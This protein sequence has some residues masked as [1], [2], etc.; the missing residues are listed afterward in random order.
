MTANVL[1]IAEGGVKTH[2][3]FGKCTKFCKTHKDCFM[4]V[5]PAFGNTLLGD[6][7]FILLI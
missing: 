1:G 3:G 5:S 7:F 2:K 4:P 6:V